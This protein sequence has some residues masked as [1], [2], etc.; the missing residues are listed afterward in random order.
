MQEKTLHQIEF[1]KFIK[2]KDDANL[3]VSVPHIAL[4][5]TGAGQVDWKSVDSWPVVLK[6]L[7]IRSQKH[8]HMQQQLEMNQQ[9]N[10][11]IN[12]FNSEINVQ[13]DCR[14]RNILPLLGFPFEFKRL[15]TL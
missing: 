10:N 3:R 4:P 9:A 7:R 15:A 5:K 8:E 13:L 14:H 2:P 6:I 12:F 1:E 11:E